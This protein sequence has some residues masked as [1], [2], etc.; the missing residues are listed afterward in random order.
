LIPTEDKSSSYFLGPVGISDPLEFIEAESN[1]VPFISALERPHAWQDAFKNWP[2]PPIAGWRN[3]YKRILDNKSIKSSN[4][5]NLRIAQCL[6][7]SLAETPK[8]ENLLIAACHFWSND[9]N[10]FL[11]GYGPMSPTLADV[12]MMTDLDVT[13]SMYPYKYK[14]SAKQRGVKTRSGYKQYIQNHMRGGPP[15]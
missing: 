1:R 2:L 12:Y 11:F 13:G 6:E 14:S 4:W 9:V 10:A 5:D 3:W 7:L 15:V 8:N